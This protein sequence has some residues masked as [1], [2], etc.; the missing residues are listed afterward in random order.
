[1]EWRFFSIKPTRC[2]NISNLFLHKTL[3]VSGSSS[4]FH[5]ESLTVHSALVCVMQVLM[6]AY[7]QGHVIQVC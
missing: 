1:M 5:Q 6:T 4:A 7:G 2:N 3:H